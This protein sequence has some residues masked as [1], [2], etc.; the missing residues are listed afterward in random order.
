MGIRNT[1]QL[2]TI[3]KEIKVT[4]C[5]IC[6]KDTESVEENGT[7][8]SIYPIMRI[9]IEYDKYEYWDDYTFKTFDICSY[10]CMKAFAEHMIIENN[11][12]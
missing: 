4:I 3:V 11:K 2:K 5:D 1:E 6:G 9:E 8:N 12:P 10:E 7:V